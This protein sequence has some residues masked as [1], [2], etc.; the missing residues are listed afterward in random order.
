M[1]KKQL[2]EDARIINIR[3]SERD[4]ENFRHTALAFSLDRSELMRR[5]MK[6]EIPIGGRRIAEFTRANNLGK[7]L[8]RLDKFENSLLEYVSA[9][10][11]Q[12]DE[13]I[14][15]SKQAQINFLQESSEIRS[16]IYDLISAK[17]HI[18][19]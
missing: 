8:E 19:I 5:I 18:N 13:R 4:W 15:S 1:A 3:V 17:N 6:G 12:L 10:R 14:E 16:D 2:P 9:H 7:I 11:Q